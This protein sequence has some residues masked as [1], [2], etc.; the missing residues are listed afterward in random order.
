MAR[1]REIRRDQLRLLRAPIF[2]PLERAQRSALVRGNTAE[3]AAIELKLQALRDVTDD[4]AIE[5]A[6]TPE[7]LK[8]VMPAPLREQILSIRPQR[9]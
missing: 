2:E 8:A 3:A 6:Q 9:T 4:P 5:D 7:E 1:A